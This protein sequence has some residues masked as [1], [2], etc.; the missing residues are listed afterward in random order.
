MKKLIT[1]SILLSSL[2]YSQDR[3]IIFNTGTAP[4]TCASSGGT[5]DNYTCDDMC[6]SHI[7]GDNCIIIEEGYVIGQG[8]RAADRFTTTYDY[9]FEAFGVYIK[10]NS[11]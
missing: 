4:W 9:A 11:F 2:I 5:Y 7:T 10:S 6:D 8:Y 1:L 3:S